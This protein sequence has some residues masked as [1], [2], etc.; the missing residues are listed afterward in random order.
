MTNIKHTSYLILSFW[1]TV[2]CNGFLEEKPSKSLVVPES[3]EDIQALMDVNTNHN[4]ESFVLFLQSDD[5][6]LSENLVNEM[7][8]W[9]RNATLWKGD[10][11][12]PSGVTLE[13]SMY[14]EK[15]FYAHLV[16]E[17]LEEGGFSDQQRVNDLKGQALFYRAFGYFSLAQLYLPP[18]LSGKDSDEKILP[19]RT[20][21]QIDLKATL[22]TTAEI[23]SSIVS[24][25]EQAINLLPEQALY[26]TRPSRVAALGMLSRVN[27][28]MGDFEEARLNSESALQIKSDLMNYSLLDSADFYPFELLNEEVIFHGVQSSYSLIFSTDL[29]VSNELYA[30]YDS[31]DLR[32]QLYFIPNAEGEPNFRGSYSGG[33][34]FFSGIAVDE[35]LLTAA[36]ANVRTGNITK[37]MEHLNRL[38]SSRWKEGLYV[39]RGADNLQE[40]LSLILEE[41]RKSL[42]F[43]ATRWMDLQRLNQEP[44]FAK[45]LVRE[46][47]E[48]S[49]S[50]DLSKEAYALKVPSRELQLEGID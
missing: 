4:V 16:M 17:L 27:L 20:V 7:N 10:I 22:A 49:G 24:D 39:E 45:E 50:L 13:F 43:R 31:L 40:A 36:E 19:Y 6:D 11:E 41:R 2:G 33:F 9:Q 37:G 18:Y 12:N 8:E 32:K 34:E 14:Y 42:V 35:I 28:A 21:S 25:L 1:I 30:S 44:E 15:I 47:G 26:P 23:Y 46:A 48:F 38:L 3:L 29:L 5:F